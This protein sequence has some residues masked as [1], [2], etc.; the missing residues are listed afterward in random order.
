MT[1]IRLSKEIKLI[2]LESVTPYSDKTINKIVKF[3]SNNYRRRK[4]GV[5]K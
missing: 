1:R 2:L 5:R 3:I 4:Y